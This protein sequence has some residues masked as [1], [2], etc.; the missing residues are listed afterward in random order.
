MNLLKELYFYLDHNLDKS[1][2]YPGGIYTQ[3]SYNS[4][5][6][7]DR[8]TVIY[9]HNMKAGTMFHG[10]LSY[11]TEDYYKEHKTIYFD[12]IDNNGKYEVIAAFRT[13]IN[14]E[15]ENSFKYYQFYD[16]ESAEEFDE[17]KYDI[18]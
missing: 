17:F 7:E 10:L 9:G 12:T 16:A 11:E 3:K 4:T 13:E 6:F 18:K 14:E 15:D 8:M 2:G 5:D 1:A